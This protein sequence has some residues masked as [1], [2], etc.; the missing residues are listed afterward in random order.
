VFQNLTVHGGTASLL[1][2]YRTAAVVGAWRASKSVDG[3]WQL[4]AT[5]SHVDAAQLE[6]WRLVSRD[7]SATGAPLRR[8][9][10]PLLFTA[11]HAHG[12]WT[13]TVEALEIGGGALY[14]TL[15]PPEQ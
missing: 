3:A 13:W 1:W 2:G 10:M 9:G 14:A 12:F 11:P 5:V 7:R 15:G 6:Q 4:A 8:Q